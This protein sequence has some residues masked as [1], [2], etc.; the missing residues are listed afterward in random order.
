MLYCVPALCSTFVVCAKALFLVP[1]A[2]SPG[3]FNALRLLIA[4]AIQL[5]VLMVCLK[6][7]QKRAFL[8]AGAELGLLNFLTNFLQIVGLKFTQASRA[9][10]VNQTQVVLVPVIAAVAGLEALS[11][12]IVLSAVLA[13]LG[14]SILTLGG[15]LSTLSSS[16]IGDILELLSA[17]FSSVYILRVGHHVRNLSTNIAGFMAAKAS[18]QAFLSVLWVL[19]AQIRKVVLS[20]RQSAVP[21]STVVASVAMGTTSLAAWT[22][23][24]VAIN[25]AVVLWCGIMVAWFAAWLHY[26]GQTAVSA[27][28]TTII[29]STQPVWAS[30]LATVLLS[31]TFG[32][33]TMLGGA[34]IIVGSVLSSWKKEAT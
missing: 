22:P 12:Q 20:C 27:S 19:S 24:L 4:A 33:V 32:P 21:S 26:H 17:V 16:F 28:E 15:G 10:F 13:L 2:I 5:P 9:A 31:E 7:P 25:A 30:L 6:L 23:R 34:L 3:A 14:V 29:F 11:T 1:R 18:V 8:T